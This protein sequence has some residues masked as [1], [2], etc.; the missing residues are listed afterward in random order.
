MYGIDL[1]SGAGGMSLGASWAG[2]SVPLAI[3]YDQHAYSSY[4]RNHPDTIT[5]RA[6]ITRV[7]E[8]SVPYPAEELVLF[9]GP[10]CQGFSTSNQRNRG[11]DND[12]NWLYRAFIG[13]ACS[14]RPR[15]IV[16]E[17]VKGILETDGGRFAERVQGDLR[18]AG[19]GVTAGILNASN[20]GVPQRRNRYFIIAR[21]EGDPPELPGGGEGRT[22]T[23]EDAIGDLPDLEMGASIDTLPYRLPP[24][25]AYQKML[26]GD[27]QEVSGNL[28]TNSSQMI[29]ERYASVPQGGNW[30][31]IP[32]ELMSNYADRSR[33]HTGIYRRLRGDQ[34][35]VVL[36]NFRKNML[37]HPTKNR[38][39]SVREAA[40]IQS[41]PDWYQFSGSIGL[42][43]QQVGNA[44][45]P[46]LAKAVF[47]TIMN[48]EGKVG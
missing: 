2:I 3:D 27:L 13:L 20:Y 6:D 32:L 42:Q 34:P 30:Q 19:Y 10:P 23:V 7:L 45:P 28:V 44:V 21:Y 43:Q 46:L 38:G 47:A 17:N 24:S 37:I 41:F 48:A 40:R 18:D 8:L 9:G 16:F 26:R 4:A 31:D 36:G 15:W 5:L 25:N 1:F 22:I 11:A 33:C 12:K 39:L 29:A 35:S 14:L